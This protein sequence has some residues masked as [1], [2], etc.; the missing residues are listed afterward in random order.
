[1]R[2]LEAK[3]PKPN[4]ALETLLDEIRDAIQLSDFHEEQNQLILRNLKQVVVYQK[5]LKEEWDS[6]AFPSKVKSIIGLLPEYKSVERML[7]DPKLE[8]PSV[9]TALY[10]IDAEIAQDLRVAVLVLRRAHF[11]DIK[12]WIASCGGF[13]S[14]SNKNELGDE[15]SRL[16]QRYDDELDHFGLS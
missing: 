9:A 15:C 12:A 2:S 14:A 13:L 11:A 8:N 7:A 1:M 10:E 16:E 3:V 5:L 4:K 6:L